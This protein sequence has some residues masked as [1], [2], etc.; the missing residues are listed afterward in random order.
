MAAITLVFVALF[1]LPKFLRCG[2]YTIP[3]F[4]EYRYNSASRAIMAIFMM[5]M[6]VAVA[7]ASILYSG[8]IGLKTIFGMN[9]SLAVWL[10][11]IIA[12][13]Y[14]IYGGLKAVVWT[15]LFQGATLLIGGAIVMVLGF[16]A[17]GGTSAFF[18]TNADKLHMIMPLDH[19]EIPWTALLL[20]L[21]I[22]NLFYWGLISS[23]C[24]ERLGPRAYRRFRRA[25]CWQPV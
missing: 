25:S 16:R 22:P 12:G 3:E 13:A 15:D 19:P 9:L 21:W 2:I 5:I 23:L 4:L 1:L 20:G 11:G 17:V 24:N 8:A 14:T 10:I 18:E 6:Y 7:L